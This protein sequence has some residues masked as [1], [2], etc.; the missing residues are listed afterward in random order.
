MRLTGRTA[1][2][3][4]AALLCGA[5]TAPYSVLYNFTIGAGGENP[6]SPLVQG[7]SGIVYGTTNGGGANGQGT[8]Y[9]FNIATGQQAPL[10]AFTQMGGADALVAGPGGVLYGALQYG[11]KYGAIFTFNPATAAYAV[12]HTFTANRTGTDGFAPIAVA[13][14]NN[15]TVYGQAGL[16]GEGSRGTVFQIT[17]QGKLR[18]L[19]AFSNAG[20]SVPGT[21]TLIGNALYGVICDKSGGTSTLYKIP[22]ATGKPQTLYQFTGGS[23][24]GCP[25]GRVVPAGHGV[26]DGIASTG[27]SH[28]IGVIYQVN[29]TTGAETVLFNFPARLRSPPDA[30]LPGHSGIIYGVR[31]N[32][33]GVF[34][35]DTAKQTSKQLGGTAGEQALQSIVPLPGLLLEGSNLYGLTAMGGDTNVGTLF[36]VAK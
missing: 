35:F 30:I 31:G 3:A 21:I 28:G 11:P 2:A 26:L 16:G 9:S 12:L 8:L 33:G 6:S 20:G 29:E 19:L 32:P 24:G 5:A 1:L 27:G 36:S 22:T 25:T 18:V 7:S 4:I 17:K 34:A 23:D 10:Y 13:V 14:A 15:G